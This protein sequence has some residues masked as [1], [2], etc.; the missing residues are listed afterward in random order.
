[1]T[2]KHENSELK[3]HKDDI[4]KYWNFRE[5]DLKKPE[6]NDFTWS[7]VHHHYNKNS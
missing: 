2:L 4:T 7:K 3:A 6:Y 5:S 1:V